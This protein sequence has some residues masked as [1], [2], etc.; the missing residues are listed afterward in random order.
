MRSSSAG[1]FIGVQINSLPA[2]LRRAAST[3]RQS[4]VTHR[5]SAVTLLLIGM[6]AVVRV[7]SAGRELVVAYEFGT[8]D[9]LDAFLMAYVVPHFVISVVIGSFTSALLPTFVD[10]REKQGKIAAK[11]L[12]ENVM[13][14]AL[15]LLGFT[16]FV[17][18]LS[19]PAALRLLASGFPPEKLAFAVQLQQLLLPLI[20]L[21][22]AVKFWGSLLNAGEHFR[23][24][25]FTNVAAP[26]ATV[27]LVLAFGSWG[28]VRLLA[29]GL[30]LGHFIQACILARSALHR[31]LPIVPQWHGLDEPTRLVLRQYAPLTLGT[32]MAG[33][34]TLVDQSM[35]AMLGSG[36]V[37]SLT[38]G[39]K[40]TGMILAFTASPI[41]IALLPYLSRQVASAPLSEARRS[42]LGWIAVAVLLTL[43]M[44]VAIFL[45]SELIVRLVF[46]RGAF[47]ADD[48]V[49]VGTIQA[50]Y[51]LQLPF[52]LAGI[53]GARMLS[54]LRLNHILAIIGVLNFTSNI[55][56]NWLFMK[57]FGL[58][59][60]ALSTSFVYLLSAIFIIAYLWGHLKRRPKSSTDGKEGL[61]S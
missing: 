46:E 31:G 36:S 32:L 44:S 42:L 50:M 49:L 28:G 47:T 60:I 4:P 7:V 34:T 61:E 9:A 14:A 27:V 52:Y 24:V 17:L 39:S 41:G 59:G 35:A 10:V 57:F 38:Y 23:L 26:L 56:F 12:A 2:R 55:F 45:G 51:V 29:L 21:H 18:W 15:A 30:L 11:R 6:T 40:L 20:F 37:S 19:G 3:W 54:A 25:A 13:T 53:I 1:A 5:I 43:P 22:G 48:T 8:S 58:P 16:V 33:G